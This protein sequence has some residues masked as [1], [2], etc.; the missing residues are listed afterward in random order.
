[1]ILENMW[2][3]FFTICKNKLT[4]HVIVAKQMIKP[5]LQFNL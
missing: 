2:A 1:M 5:S 3:Y 4:T